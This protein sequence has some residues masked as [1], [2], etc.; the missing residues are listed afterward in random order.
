MKRSIPV[1]KPGSSTADVLTW[2]ED[3][4][5]DTATASASARSNQPSDGISKVVFGGQV[6]DG[7][8]QSL[9]NKDRRP[10]SGYKMKEMRGSGIFGSDHASEP[11]NRPGLRMYQE[12]VSGISQISLGA[13][14]SVP[15]KPTSVPQ[16]QVAKQ[17]ELRGTLPSQSDSK[18][19]RRISSSKYKEISG[20]DIFAFAFAFAP[21]QEIKPT[22]SKQSMGIPIPRN[23]PTPVRVSNPPGG[24]TGIPLG[25]EPVIK[26]AKKI[27]D[28][29]FQDLTGNDIFKEAVAVDPGSS[30]KKLSRA[31]LREMRGN[32][33]FS[34]GKVESRDY[35]G[36]IRKPPGGESS[37][38]L[39]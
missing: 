37:I 26:T 22:G 27:H 24:H 10:C 25:G 31:K 15:K 16:A 1:R 6:T 39:V 18:H 19:K 9:L 33:I 29:K 4:V 11:T 20:H 35:L 30:E 5:S 2:T 36:G 3:P 14:G 12:A 32:D 23:V 13:D 21:P 38:S 17:R 7:E 28:Q 8:P 34:D